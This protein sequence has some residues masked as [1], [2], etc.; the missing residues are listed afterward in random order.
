MQ[1]SW[2]GPS[3][4]FA[5]HLERAL[6]TFVAD[7]GEAGGQACGHDNGARHAVGF[8]C[9]AAGVGDRTVVD[10]AGGLAFAGGSVDASEAHAGGLRQCPLGEGGIRLGQCGQDVELGLAERADVGC[11]HAATFR[12]QGCLSAICSSIPLMIGFVNIWVWDAS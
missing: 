10:V 12:S 7:G 2:V 9:L 5:A 1:H 8:E 6:G 11:G 4:Y 3:T